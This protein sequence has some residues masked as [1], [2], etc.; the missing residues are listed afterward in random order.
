MSDK[1]TIVSVPRTLLVDMSH[2][3][4]K[5][6]AAYMADITDLLDAPVET[7]EQEGAR[8][9]RSNPNLGSNLWGSTKREGDEFN[10]LA[11][12]YYSKTPLAVDQHAQARRDDQTHNNQLL[13]ARAAK[14][15]PGVDP[16]NTS[17][18]EVV[19]ELEKQFVQ[20][21][22]KPCQYNSDK[23][24]VDCPVCNGTGLVVERRKED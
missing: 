18:F 5:R 9:A 20:V 19:G 3:Q 11:D 16:T 10:R 13:M 14:L 22:C 7:P 1:E 21:T 23:P 6:V 17:W 12:A 15:L 24:R 8:L 4:N 2:N